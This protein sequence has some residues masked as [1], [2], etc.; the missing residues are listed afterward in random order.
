MSIPKETKS[1]YIDGITTILDEIREGNIYQ[2][3]V[4]WRSPIFTIKNHLEIYLRLQK[5][6]LPD[7]DAG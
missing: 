1:H 2:C 4:A 7:L 5:Q 6:I 3:N